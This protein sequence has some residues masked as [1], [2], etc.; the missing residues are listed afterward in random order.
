MRAHIVAAAQGK[1]SGP[2]S[3]A[4]MVDVQLTVDPAPFG[5]LVRG[6]EVIKVTLGSQAEVLGVKVGWR[7]SSIEG[8]EV[9]KSGQAAADAITR[10]LASAKRGGKPYTV[11]CHRPT[12]PPRPPT[13]GS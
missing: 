6:R 1:A 9:P 12:S 13:A 5:V 10:A 2:G 8:T 3:S 11:M 7:L 4:A